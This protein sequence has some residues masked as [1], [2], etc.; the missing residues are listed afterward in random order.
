MMAS[1]KINLKQSFSMNQGRV[2]YPA[3]GLSDLRILVLT[4]WHILTSHNAR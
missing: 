3:P 2:L 4:L 1:T